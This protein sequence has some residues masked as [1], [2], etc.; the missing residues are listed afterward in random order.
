MITVKYEGT[1]AYINRQVAYATVDSGA[2]QDAVY[3]PN[4]L[5]EFHDDGFIEIKANKRPIWFIPGNVGVDP[6]NLSDNLRCF[7]YYC[8]CGG[9]PSADVHSAC[10]INKSETGV[11]RCFTSDS[12]S[13]PHGSGEFCIGSAAIVPCNMAKEEDEDNLYYEHYF[14]GVILEATEVVLTDPPGIKKKQNNTLDF[15]EDEN[16][17][18]YLRGDFERLQKEKLQKGN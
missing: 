16:G 17:D 13:C 1:K 6:I 9:L 4:E 11:I 18:V 15:I 12:E 8:N 2:L 14:G 10:S 5:I 3:F 7:R